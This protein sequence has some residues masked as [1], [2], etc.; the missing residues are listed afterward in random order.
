LHPI[1]IFEILK[2]LSLVG[3]CSPSFPN[4]QRHLRGVSA[5][6]FSEKIRG[7][8]VFAT[9]FVG[10]RWLKMNFLENF[11][12][13]RE[14]KVFLFGLFNG[15]NFLVNI[16]ILIFS[17]EK[18]IVVLQKKS[19]GNNGEFENIYTRGGVCSLVSVF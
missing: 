16:S 5:W 3:I 15:K 11:F 18:I 19:K 14:E 4:I 12:V 17:C 9:S 8:A 6:L 13:A 7:I 2:R 10:H 1:E